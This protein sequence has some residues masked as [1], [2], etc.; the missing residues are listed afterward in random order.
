MQAIR[1][2]L[3]ATPG[4]AGVHD[5][6]T[7]KMGDMIVVDAHLEIDASIT[8]EVTDPNSAQ[9]AQQTAAASAT[10]VLD[11]LTA[12]GWSLEKQRA[13]GGH[14]RPVHHDLEAA[15][16]AEMEKRRDEV[17]SVIRG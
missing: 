4:V 11:A 2:T 8:V 16:P 15:T 7:R 12:G 5:V 1:A 9:A 13:A 14:F 3:L 6:R 17:L 10:K